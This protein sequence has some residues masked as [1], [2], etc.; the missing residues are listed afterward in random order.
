MRIWL[1]N[2]FC[3]LDDL[4]VEEQGAGLTVCVSQAAVSLILRAIKEI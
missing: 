4:C 2:H 1:P 3:Y